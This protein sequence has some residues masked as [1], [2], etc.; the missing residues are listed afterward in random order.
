M[1]IKQFGALVDRYLDGKASAG[2]IKAVDQWLDQTDESSSVI[3]DLERKRLQYEMLGK[4]R[5]ALPKKSPVNRGLIIRV[6]KPYLRIAAVLA[7]FASVAWFYK[8]Y[9]K[10]F[11]KS[12]SNAVLYETYRTPKGRKA[13]LILSD[14]SVIKLNAGTVIKYPKYF[15]GSTREVILE[16]GEAFF[17]ITPNANKP[18]IVQTTHQIDTRVLGTSFNISN[19]KLSNELIL[20]VNTGK[21]QVNKSS[22]KSTRSLGIFTP[23]QGLTYNVKNGSFKPHEMDAKEMSAW[24][25]NILVLKDADFNDVKRL[26]ENWYGIDINLDATPS[27]S[28]LFTGRYF[29]KSLREVLGSL[30][31]INHFE[32]ELKENKLTIM[33]QT[34]HQK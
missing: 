12:T 18:F 2:E 30:Q 11:E 3:S 16:D 32:Y 31:R 22:G 27:S 9:L 10:E 7:V 17:E 21:V 19:Y 26:L 33:N 25:N 14:S 4:I 6:I 13:V 5:Q 24:K 29:N 8:N 15:K 23:G 20:S 1:N 28:M 34:K